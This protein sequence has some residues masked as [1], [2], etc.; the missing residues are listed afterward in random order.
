MEKIDWKRKLSS[1]KFWL[2]ICS[3]A[4]NLIIAFGGSEQLAVQ[5][6][7]IIMATATVVAY[8]IAEGLV[9]KANA[10]SGFVSGYIEPVGDEETGDPDE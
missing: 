7:G 4:T 1:R 5:V 2:A 8:I 9:D 3:L 6:T 10:D